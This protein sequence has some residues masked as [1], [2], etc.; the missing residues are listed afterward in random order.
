M[1]KRP[2]PLMQSADNWLRRT[3]MSPGRTAVFGLAIA[4]AGLFLAQPVQAQALTLPQAL[5][6]IIGNIVLIL[7]Q[8]VGALTALSAHV[9]LLVSEYNHFID[10][11]VVKTGWAIVRDITNMF[12]IIGLMIIAAGTI[13]RLENYRYNR[14]LARLVIMAFLVNFSRLIA[15]FFIQSAQVVML[16]FVNSYKDAFFGNFANMFGLAEVLQFA[17]QGQSAAIFS[18][19]A[20]ALGCA[21]G[22]GLSA[23]VISLIAGLAMM[24]VALI[25]TLAIAAVLIIRVVALWILIILSPLAYALRILPQ[26]EGMAKRWWSEFGRYVTVGPVLAFI[27]WLSLAIL[28][29]TGTSQ[30]TAFGTL[31]RSQDEGVG[32]LQFCS[33]ILQ[34]DKF[35]GF[36]VATIF[37]LMGL[38]YATDSGVVG[39][40]LAT[41]L[42]TGAGLTVTGVAALRDRTLAP[43]QGWIR[44]RQASRRSAIEA[45]TQ[46]LEAAGD[47]ARAAFSQRT[48]IGRAGGERSQ[49]A[50]E[51]YEKQRSQRYSQERGMANW[52]QARLDAELNQAMGNNS[53]DGRRRRLAIT[54]H[55]QE[56]GLLDLQRPLHDA[57]VQMVTTDLR[58]GGEERRQ[59]RLKAAESH[60]KTMEDEEEI[61]T[62]ILAATDPE[63][64]LTY[65]RRLEQRRAGRAENPADVALYNKIR[66]NLGRLPQRLK[67]FDDA[68]KKSNPEMA[69]QTVFSR[70]GDGATTRV[71]AEGDIKRYLADVQEGLMRTRPL[72]AER[73][74]RIQN[75]LTDLGRKEGLAPAEATDYGRNFIARNLVH[76]ARTKDELDRAL[77]DMEPESLT[78]LLDGARLD[79]AD[80]TAPDG[81]RAL[82]EERQR[83]LADRHFYDE[84]FTRL[85]ADGEHKVNESAVKQYTAT[86]EKNIK[87]GYETGAISNTTLENDRIMRTFDGL[88]SID[89]E[90][91]RKLTKNATKRGFYGRMKL[92]QIEG[93]KFGGADFSS[94]T[95]EGRA[96]L[97]LARFLAVAG[98]GGK[99]RN[100]AGT[101]VESLEAVYA[102]APGFAVANNPKI[103][104]Q[105]Q[106]AFENFVRTN[107]DELTRMD[108]SAFKSNPNFQ[109]TIVNNINVRDL[110]AIHNQNTKSVIDI[111]YKMREKFANQKPDT[112]E[113]KRWEKIIDR[114][115]RNDILT[116]LG[117][118]GRPTPPPTPPP[119]V[120]PP[121][122]PQP[123]PGPGES[124][125]KGGIILT[126]GARF[127][128]ER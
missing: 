61:R 121:T 111:V 15:G 1:P 90:A 84:A 122:R 22:G 77:N 82:D 13:L 8:T 87:E 85:N 93:L 98:R 104:E 50:A 65:L 74:A 97:K 62:R 109:E 32:A 14:L 119:T 35:T 78:A 21:V 49:A 59:F 4:A 38:K 67:D 31:A 53:P 16:T 102:P 120:P 54:Q 57:A 44:N 124:V 91:V 112:D 69:I 26:T 18:G 86:N 2:I 107:G 125:S 72:T 48:G 116:G 80:K 23:V 126:P 7:V 29:S 99:L 42:A 56:R 101:E 95:K 106:S 55:M 71:D 51:V 34:F 9:I 127:D 89:D 70:L 24:V 5:M 37:M 10:V 60:A 113:Y 6:Q 3:M 96:N 88:D 94:D 75:H 105:L 45:R 117:S 40:R 12:F 27:L 118:S 20:G 114:I 110:A 11:S 28:I 25:V 103:D 64:Q 100:R 43:V 92:D 123:K 33:A 19:D 83:L 58:M 128:L 63:E 115:D 46:T 76:G 81:I 108:F 30:D 66:A 47:R 41:G 36:L 79:Y 52:D 73:Q 39:A 17:A 68:L